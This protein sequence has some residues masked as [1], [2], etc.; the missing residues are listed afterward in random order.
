M[1]CPPRPDVVKL[2]N[3]ASNSKFVTNYA[4]ANE[5]TCNN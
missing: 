4:A 5:I 3:A 2:L 1:I